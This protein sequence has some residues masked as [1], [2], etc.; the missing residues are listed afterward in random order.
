MTRG[1]QYPGAG[2]ETGV[3]HGR[4]Q[5]ADPA[6]GRGGVRRRFL[7]LPDRKWGAVLVVV[8]EVVHFDFIDQRDVHQVQQNL[9]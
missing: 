2:G 1:R 7:P 4:R 8:L 5:G 3:V 6:G 9:P